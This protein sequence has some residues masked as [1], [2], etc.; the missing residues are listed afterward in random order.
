MVKKP[1]R[2]KMLKEWED[3]RNYVKYTIRKDNDT[4]KYQVIIKEK[5]N[6][7]WVEYSSANFEFYNQALEYFHKEIRAHEQ[8]YEFRRKPQWVYREPY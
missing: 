4:S 1:R 2:Y 6:S 5:E 3:T 8:Y 7:K